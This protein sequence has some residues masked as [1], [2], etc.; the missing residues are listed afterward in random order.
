MFEIDIHVMST[1][2]GGAANSRETADTTHT[3]ARTATPARLSDP[4]M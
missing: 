1:Y 4:I 2:A 3:L